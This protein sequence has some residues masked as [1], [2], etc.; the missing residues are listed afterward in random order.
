VQRQQRTAN[1]DALQAQQATKCIIV[2][3][4]PNITSYKRGRPALLASHLQVQ[5][6]GAEEQPQYS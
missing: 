5:C 4:L 2:L 3:T 6:Q 1:F